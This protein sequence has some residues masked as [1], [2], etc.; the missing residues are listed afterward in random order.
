MPEIFGIPHFHFDFEW[1]KTKEGYA[2][3]ALEILREA[4][5]LLEKYP[6][7]KF[8]IDTATAVEPALGNREL[9]E[10]LKKFA[11]E[12]R[13]EFV[14]G[15]LAAPDENLPCG[16]ALVRQ[17]LAGK[18]FLRENFGVECPTGWLIDE[19]GHTLQLPQ[20]L[21]KCGFRSVTF[22]RGFRWF[23]RRPVDFRWVAPD[24]SE[25][26]AHW[27]S[28]S[29]TGFFPLEPS[30]GVR[31]ARYERELQTHISWEIS[32]TGHFLF[33]MGGDFTAPREEWLE[34]VEAWNRRN[35][36]KVRIAVPSEFFREVEKQR[37]R[38][39]IFSGELNPIFTGTYESRERVKKLCR[40]TE[41]TLLDAEK[42]SSLCMLLGGKYPDLEEEWRNLLL[43][44]H[45]DLITG[46]GT[47]TVY[48]NTLLRYH[49]S[50]RGAGGKRLQALEHLS[51][52]VRTEGEGKPLLIF[53]T[54]SWPRKA[55]V[56]VHG[57]YRVFAR[58]RELPC[59]YSEGRT[60]F[61]AE[62]P[63]MGYSLFHLRE[64]EARIFETDL[65]VRGI[66]LENTF[67]RVKVGP[68]GV[69]SVFDKEERR[70]LIDAR[71][72]SG[73]ELLVE[74][75]VGNLWTI[76]RTG[77]RWRD[78]Y[79]TDV[80]VTERG[81]VRATVEISGK[82]H[83]M[84]RVQR[85]SLYSG[86]KGVF[87]ETLIDFKGRDCRVR[88]L[89]P[90]K[91]KRKVVHE[92]PFGY[93]ERGDGI[94]PVQNW[95]GILEDGFGIYLVN[96]GI[97]SCEVN[98]SLLS[99][100]LMRSVSVLSLPL[101]LHVLRNLGDIVRTLLRG[102]LLTLRGYRYYEEYIMNHHY[103]MIREYASRGPPVEMR[104]G[105]TV[106]DHLYP[107]FTSWRESDAWERGRH[108]FSYMLFSHKGGIE[109][110]ARRGM[111]FNFPPITHL[112][113]THGGRL[114]PEKSFLTLSPSNVLL[115]ALKKAERGKNLVV[116]IYEASGRETNFKLILAWPVRKARK[117]SMDEG[118]TYEELDATGRRVSGKLAP[119]EICT[120]LL[121]V[122]S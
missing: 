88:A 63:S 48:M 31:M 45:H 20:I 39:P 46:T 27:L 102:T 101:A 94:W 122:G 6:E 90:L 64:G 24:G 85:V 89:F 52:L 57:I 84:V 21:R 107:Y 47:D 80:R 40:E 44:N 2:K 25:V 66:N 120:I 36:P 95:A 59:Q 43:N 72:F 50:L 113:T 32:P 110:A 23:E 93:V 1:W 61:L 35:Q 53:N 51:S 60:F 75:D 121:E 33:P 76:C 18:K 105:V 92:V 91:S 67:Y 70:E 81:P 65:R 5:E 77:R 87:F 108:T 62:L 4:V 114:P 38:L 16:E 26:L 8:T 82:H 111:E 103:L 98:G 69:L 109:E 115:V 13:V 100:G 79:P 104:G 12:G 71:T 117:V 7:F 37:E 96:R 116:R 68:H 11:G 14:G 42:L 3:D 73:G 28:L 83:G 97:P 54:L 34:A 58:G 99:L 112:T 86:I 106:P 55:L 119:H 22:G 49:F 9:V 10:K 56:E 41:T 30:K 15:T 17:F 74:E 29:Y 78:S 118:E 19:F